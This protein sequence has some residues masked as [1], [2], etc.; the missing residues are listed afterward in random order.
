M[1]LGITIPIY[2]IFYLLV[3]GDYGV[4]GLQA[5][6]LP[7]SESFGLVWRVWGRDLMSREG[8]NP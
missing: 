6:P 1:A 2:P 5:L 7:V 8:L 3:K 4:A